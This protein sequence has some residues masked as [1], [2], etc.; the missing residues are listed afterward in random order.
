[1][2]DFLVF[3]TLPAKLLGAKVIAFMKEPSPELAET[4]FASSLVPRVYRVI[5]RLVLRYADLVFTVTEDLKE[6]Y[7]ARGADAGKIRVVLNGPD[8]QYWHAPRRPMPPAPGF[9]VVCHGSIEDRYGHDVIVQAVCLVRDRLPDLRVRIPGDG[10]RADEVARL[11][12]KLGVEDQIELLGWLD[13]DDLVKELHQADVGLVAQRSSPYSNLV[14]TIKMYDYLLFGKPVVASRLR[15][16][17]RYFQDGSVRYFRPDDPVD[18]AEALLE[19]HDCPERRRS[20][21]EA[22]S[23]RY[24]QLGWA[25]QRK[26]LTDGYDELL[27]R[28]GA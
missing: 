3:C 17:A 2:P 16:T 11:I 24:E 25:T 18:L 12:A 14:H 19:L 20:L 8:P 28:R 10:T 23:R 15:S 4:L 5:E 26:I 27:G 22:G 13:H 6:V 7:V 9:T 21:A 1:M